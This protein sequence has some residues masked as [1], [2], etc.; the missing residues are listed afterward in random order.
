MRSSN[1]PLDNPGYF[2][3]FP[4][5]KEVRLCYIITL[6]LSQKERK[7]EGKKEK[8]KASNN[9]LRKIGNLSHGLQ[10]PR[11]SGLWLYLPPLC[12]LPSMSY[13][14]HI[15]SNIFLPQDLW[16]CYSLCL[17]MAQMIKNL[18]ARWETQVWPLGQEDPLEKG[19]A[20]HSSIC[21][22]RIP[23]TNEHGGL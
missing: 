6:L 7:R 21:A 4:A 8:D 23:W 15:M 14:H 1:C 9:T 18:P 10:L 19:M 2:C 11:Q 5:K 22:W 3:T 17:E 13:T 16:T 20:P 12:S